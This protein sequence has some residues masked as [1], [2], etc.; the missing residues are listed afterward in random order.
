MSSKANKTTKLKKITG[1]SYFLS[2]IFHLL[3]FGA[4][5]LLSI[6]A[7]PQKKTEYVEIGLGA[8]FGEG[9]GTGVG[10]ETGNTTGEPAEDENLVPEEKGADETTDEVKDTKKSEPDALPT[11]EK[12]L[13]PNKKGDNSAGKNTK[14]GGKGNGGEG[15]EGGGNGFFFDWGGSGVRKVLTYSIPDYPAGV[16][17]E[18]NVRL[19]FTIRPDGS[20]GSIIP[21]TKADTRLEDAA[22]NSLRRW[23]FEKLPASITPF[24]QVVVITFPFRLQ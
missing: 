6:G 2:V 10:N 13:N 12:T 5:Y 7:K 16:N 1:S 3:L 14:P 21:I 20:V 15:G 8:G 22:L 4:F 11:S 23:R 18:A 19:R 9:D 24:D 17:K